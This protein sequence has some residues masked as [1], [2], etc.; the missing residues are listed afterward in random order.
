MISKEKKVDFYL[1]EE[2]KDK[3]SFYGYI[4]RIDQLNGTVR[5]ID[6]KTAKTKNLSVKIDETNIDDYFHNSE[7]KQ[8]LQLCIY[9]YVV[10]SLPEFWGLPVETGIWSF[11]E[12]NKGVSSLNFDRGNLDKAMIAVK[13]IIL[14]ILNPEIS[15]VENV[16]TFAGN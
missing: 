11:A 8:A 4:D 1:N 7:R 3:I 12:A 2:T 9:Q 10:Q 6:Y 13:N 16:K 14:E 5:I 15:F